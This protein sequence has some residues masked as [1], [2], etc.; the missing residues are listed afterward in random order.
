MTDL[1]NYHQPDENLERRKAANPPPSDVTTDKPI[2]KPGMR[3]RVG[4][5]GTATSRK[6]DPRNVKFY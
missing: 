4:R 6:R 5:A 1:P 3:M 2:G